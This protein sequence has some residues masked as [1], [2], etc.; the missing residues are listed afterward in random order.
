[1]IMEDGKKSVNGLDWQLKLA[2]DR[3]VLEI[4]QKFDV[5]EIVARIL[6]SRGISA[7]EVTSFLT[8][9]LKQNLPNPFSLKDMEKAAT[10]MATAILAGEPIGI[11]GDYDVDGAT[12]T[13]ILKMFLKSCGV[14]VLTFIPNR[15]DGYGPNAGKMKEFKKAGLI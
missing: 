14:P 7:E 8:P 10:R 4:V 2:D 1:M 12:S 5:P 13:A 3:L 15:E 9:T 11:M 6:V